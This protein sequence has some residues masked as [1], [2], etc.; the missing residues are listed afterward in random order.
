MK[1][2]SNHRTASLSLP[3][4]L[5]GSRRTGLRPAIAVALTA[6]GFSA[7]ARAQSDAGDE[8]NTAHLTVGAGIAYTPRY[9]GSDEYKGRALPMA[10]YRNGRFFAG[11]MGG[12]G[13]NVSP[14]KDLEFGPLLSYRFGRDESDA[15]RLRGLGDVDGGAEVGAYARWNLR[16]FFLHAT[17]K[18]G[19]SGDVTGQS[20]KLGA[21]YATSMGAA[22]RL[23]F[24]ASLDWS[25]R[26]IMRAYYGVSAAQSVRSGLPA[27]GADAG[28]RR[29]SIGA[30]WT[31]TFSPQW[32]STL[33][34]SAYRLGDEAASSPITVDRTSGAVS[35]GVGYRF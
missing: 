35:A 16:P 27:Y 30:M 10:S 11:T 6:A 7:G 31:H 9:E 24:D 20:F 28:I 17:V 5:Q 8:A 34:V 1:N 29:Y 26:E 2:S 13:Y 32:F 21:G 12:I 14:I 19:V 15:D 22:D 3:S 25:D 33:G 4:S 18:Q 23:V